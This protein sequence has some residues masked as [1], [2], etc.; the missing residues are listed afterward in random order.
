MLGAVIKVQ[1]ALVVNRGPQQGRTQLE[2]LKGL[3]VSEAGGY[4]S[5]LCQTSAGICL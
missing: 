4:F 1:V 2:D 3:G 5:V